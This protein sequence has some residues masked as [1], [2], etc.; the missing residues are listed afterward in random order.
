MRKRV[1]QLPAT[2]D[3][4]RA[5]A[6]RGIKRPA[7]PR[8]EAGDAFALR[9]DAAAMR[10]GIRAQARGEP[11]R[12]IRQ[13]LPAAQPRDRLRAFSP[14]A[15]RNDELG[16]TAHPT[17][18]DLPAQPPVAAPDSPRMELLARR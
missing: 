8:A 11:R 3:R 15:E 7:R 16:A 13:P 14:L 6:Q 1:E 17:S 18:H 10:I 9:S 4:G 12:C 5:L 2:L